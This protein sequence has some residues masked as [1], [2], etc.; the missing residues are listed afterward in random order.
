MYIHTTPA[1][2]GGSE[3]YQPSM[4]PFRIV[5]NIYIYIPT[6]INKCIFMYKIR[7]FI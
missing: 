4:S 2:Q 1:G 7:L 3:V 6:N 5:C